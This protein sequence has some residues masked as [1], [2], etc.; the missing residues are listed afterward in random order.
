VVQ[1]HTGMGWVFGD[2]FIVIFSSPSYLVL[3][4]P[5]YLNCFFILEVNVWFSPISVAITAWI[6]CPPPHSRSNK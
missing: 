2:G 3:C 1:A 4:V 6:F 5:A